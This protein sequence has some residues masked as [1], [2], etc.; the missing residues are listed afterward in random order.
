MY[1]Y[2]FK[3]P[4]IREAA[5][6][7]VKLPVRVG[8]NRTS[9]VRHLHMGGGSGIVDSGLY[10]HGTLSISGD[11]LDW[12]K[13]DRHVFEVYRLSDHMIVGRQK[14][15][16]VCQR[17]D[18]YATIFKEMLDGKDLCPMKSDSFNIE[19]RY[20][21]VNVYKL[22]IDDGDSEQSLVMQLFFTLLCHDDGL[23][24]HA[25]YDFLKMEG[26]WSV[27]RFMYNGVFKLY[28]EADRYQFN[29]LSNMILFHINLTLLTGDI[30]MRYVLR[31]A[32]LDG[33]RFTELSLVETSYFRYDFEFIASYFR[34]NPV[35][36]IDFSQYECPVRK[37]VDEG[38]L[39]RLREIIQRGNMSSAFNPRI[40]FIRE[41]Y[42]RIGNFLELI[43]DKRRC[44]CHQ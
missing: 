4:R 13:L 28:L 34:E 16:V 18:Y 42:W 32:E 35:K 7:L 37:Y 17:S 1:R 19:H 30:N 44:K 3:N 36:E 41:G 31:D 26:I 5:I 39:N 21:G 33:G 38:D 9:L 23:F 12:H 29:D 43:N 8:Y 25:A 22:F 20:D 6:L 27:I 2:K 15:G 10:E 40:M 24:I 14:L 11:G